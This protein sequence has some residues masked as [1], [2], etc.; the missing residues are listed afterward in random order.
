MSH[1]FFFSIYRS[2]KM[3]PG[4]TFRLWWQKY[5]LIKLKNC[6]Q[7]SQRLNN[8]YFLMTCREEPWMTEVRIGFP[9]LKLRRGSLNNNMVQCELLNQ[10]THGKS[11]YLLNDVLP[12]KASHG[13]SHYA[14]GNPVMPS[15]S[16]SNVQRCE[17]MLTPLWHFFL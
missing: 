1:A 11:F 10:H 2:K 16:K 5:W 6:L 3:L 9:S 13:T 4:K 14:A 12:H 17:I 15:H 8:C 7:F